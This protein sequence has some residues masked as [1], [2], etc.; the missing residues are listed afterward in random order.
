MKRHG[1]S[2]TAA[3]VVA[4]LVWATMPA[5]PAHAEAG[6]DSVGAAITVGLLVAVV[7]VYG[8]VSLRSDVERYSQAEPDAAIARAARKVE[9]SPIV[10]QTLTV[11]IGLNS[12]S[13]GPRTEIAGAA[14][15]LRL[16]F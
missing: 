8:L 12:Q 10:L 2:G 9:E 4:A 15:G 1:W 3:M 13:A 11:P 6:D 5:P 7:A 14:I 16:R